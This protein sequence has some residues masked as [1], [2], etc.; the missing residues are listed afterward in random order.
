MLVPGTILA[1]GIDMGVDE[2][3]G[4]DTEMAEVVML[5][6]IVSINRHATSLSLGALMLNRMPR[7]QWLAWPQ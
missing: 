7:S 1:D 5:P 4:I 3:I 2:L 6:P